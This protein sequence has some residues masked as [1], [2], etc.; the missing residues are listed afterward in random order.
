MCRRK[1]QKRKQSKVILALSLLVR[2]LG[3]F[4]GWEVFLF[5]VLG[6]W[7]Q[8]HSEVAGLVNRKMMAVHCRNQVL[9]L[10]DSLADLRLHTNTWHTAAVV[11]KHPDGS[12]GSPSLG[13]SF[14]DP[15]TWRAVR[16]ICQMCWWKL[17]QSTNLAFAGRYTYMWLYVYKGPV[18]LVSGDIVPL[19]CTDLWVGLHGQEV[20]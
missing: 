8:N 3:K 4:S 12:H 2:S 1:I 9:H 13:D 19:K 15:G 10:G 7:C 17:L 20:I 18:W 6:R 5:F 11:P 16:V 14:S